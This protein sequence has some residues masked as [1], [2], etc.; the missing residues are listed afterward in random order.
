MTTWR[1]I[2]SKID[3]KEFIIKTETGHQIH[4]KPKVNVFIDLDRKEKGK[5]FYFIEFPF[6]YKKT[7]NIKNTKQ[8]SI[9]EI[10]KMTNK[11]II[12]EYWKLT[13]KQS[14]DI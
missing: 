8:M 9:E 11:R 2:N 6:E 14:H 10:K 12:D 1:N 7:I 13:E 3:L 5:P 4:F